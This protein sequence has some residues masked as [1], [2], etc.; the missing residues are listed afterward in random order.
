MDGRTYSLFALALSLGLCGCIPSQNKTVSVEAPV[1]PP[2]DFVAEKKSLNPFAAAPKREP[3]LEL[4][5]GIF[6]ERKALGMKDTPEQQFRQLDDARKIYQEILVYDNKNLQ[7]YRGLGRVYVAQRDF[8]RAKAT[9]QKAMELHPKS[10]QLYADISVISSKQ[11]DF[12]GAIEKLNKAREMEPENQEFLRMLS[13][14]LVCDGQ[15]DLGVEM[16]ARA[17]GKEA[18]H[19]YVARILDRK[20]QP[21]EAK[22]HAQLALD[23]N[24]NFNDARTLLTELNQR[25]NQARASPSAN[26]GL[27]FVSEE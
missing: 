11:N 19:Y 20:N 15:V 4:E 26:I 23:A 7:A 9:L 27:Q 18:A 24:P 8:V 10:A 1:P 22:R 25:G 5:M 12:T 21:A 13:V 2:A 3:N 17:R 16:M 14:N 6:H